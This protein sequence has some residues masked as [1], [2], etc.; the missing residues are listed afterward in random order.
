MSAPLKLGVAGLGTVG[1]GLLNLLRQNAK[2]AWKWSAALNW[3]LENVSLGAFTQYIGSV[4]DT[5]IDSAS[6]PWVVDGQLTGNV[7]AEYRF[8][9]ALKGTSVRFGVRN[10]TN[11]APPLSAGGYLGTLYSPI[12][13]YWYGNLRYRF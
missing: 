9:G 7:Y 6:A 2:P 13:R 10:F 12:G 8:T 4:E 1:A 11:E 3:S 5:S